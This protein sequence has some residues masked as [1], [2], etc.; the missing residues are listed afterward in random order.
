MDDPPEPLA[1]YWTSSRTL[2]VLP[3]DGLPVY[4][5][6][7]PTDMYLVKPVGFRSA[8]FLW[9]VTALASALVGVLA[10]FVLGTFLEFGRDD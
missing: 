6:A 8:K 5:H 1:H 2:Q 9:G 3:D 7:P 4:E 10:G